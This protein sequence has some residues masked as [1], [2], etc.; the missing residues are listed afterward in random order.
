MR[1]FIALVMASAL[2]CGSCERAENV[3]EME[4]SNENSR[5]TMVFMPFFGLDAG[6]SSWT[7]E[8]G[9]K[10][11]ASRANMADYAD[12]LLCVD[13]MDG[14]AKQKICRPA[15][16]PFSLTMDYGLHELRFLGH[17]STDWQVDEAKGVFRTGKVTETFLKC[18]P[19]EVDEDTDEKLTLQMDRVV[20]K[21]TLM[22]LD[23]IPEG[24]ARIELTVGG[25][26]A[27]LD[28]D[29]GLG[30]AEEKEDFSIGWDLNGG[31]VGE[32]GLKFSVF[33]FCEEN[34]FEVSLRV[35]ARDAEGKVLEDRMASG[36][37]LL[38]NRCTVAKGRIFSYEGGVTFSEPGDWIPEYEID[39]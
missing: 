18:V 33:S 12:S 23:A 32:K 5:K 27:A 35:V 19:M 2:L 1:N 8:D 29:T 14:V 34:E 24:V 25:H 20:A 39:F 21:L 15:E 9:M 36:I 22:I 10:R 6:I 16:E 37:P 11:R 7:A 30:V 28:M 13:Y 4:N 17:S 26:M 31:Y 38:K 3:P